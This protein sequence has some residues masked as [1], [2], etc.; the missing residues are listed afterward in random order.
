MASLPCSAQTSPKSRKK[1]AEKA[2]REPTGRPFALPDTPAGQRLG[3]FT[4]A[5]IQHH[6]SVFDCYSKFGR[7]VGLHV[8]H[9]QHTCNKVMP[10][11][12]ALLHVLHLVALT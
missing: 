4:I 1:A 11:V 3:Y 2:V 12:I 9:V 6:L 5:S 10:M 8:Q 7:R